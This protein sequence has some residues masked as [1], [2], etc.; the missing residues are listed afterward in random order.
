M[1]VAIHRPG[2]DSRGGVR[3]STSAP[4][5]RSQAKPDAISAG[6]SPNRA[7]RKVM[8]TVWPTRGRRVVEIDPASMART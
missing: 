6:E 5:A 7:T 3:T 4:C 1:T 2:D 8:R